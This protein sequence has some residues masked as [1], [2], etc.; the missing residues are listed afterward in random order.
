MDFQ[1]DINQPCVSPG[2]PFINLP[3]PQMYRPRATSSDKGGA[4]G[5]NSGEPI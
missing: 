4:S 5:P 3:A 1:N 2:D